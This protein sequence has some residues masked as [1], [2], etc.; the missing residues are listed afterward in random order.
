[1]FLCSIKVSCCFSI[2]KL[3]CIFVLL[4]NLVIAKMDYN[5]F[6]TQGKKLGYADEA[7]QEFVTQRVEI[8][9]EKR[10]QDKEKREA[11]RVE[12][13]AQRELEKLK[14]ETQKEIELERIQNEK[15]KIQQ[16]H[17]L[18]MSHHGN[19]DRSMHDSTLYNPSK[20]RLPVFDEVKDNMESYIER[21]ERWAKGRKIPEDSWALEL[22]ILLQGKLLDVYTRMGTD[23]ALDYKSLKLA[24]MERFRLTEEGF[25]QK[26]RN[27]RPEKGETPSQFIVRISFIQK[28]FEI[29]KVTSLDEA[30][31]ICIRE[32]FYRVCP[33]NLTF[34]L[35]ERECKK[36]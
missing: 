19:A 23:K 6:I 30:I 14:L 36:Y 28:W 3:V 9:R 27:A 25:R 5:L 13:N 29:A 26:F 34:Y 4:G 22:G 11:E 32:Q 2:G 10:K 18:D 17:E 16:D 1:M 31:D 15:L 7:L 8:E 33:N 35:K 20:S 12:R 24:L 21:F